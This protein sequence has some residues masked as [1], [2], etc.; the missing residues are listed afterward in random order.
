MCIGMSVH[1]SM[2][3]CVFS[4]VDLYMHMCL[5]MCIHMYICLLSNGS[6]KSLSVTP[7]GHL[8]CHVLLCD[9]V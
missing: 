2:F 7:C 6:S 5:C 4:Y 8:P 1:V 9:T 3:L